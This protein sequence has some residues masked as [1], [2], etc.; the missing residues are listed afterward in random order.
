MGTAPAGYLAPCVAPDPIPMEPVLAAAGQDQLGA[1]L[2]STPRDDQRIFTRASAHQVHRFE[3]GLVV[4]TKK[5]GP[6][7]LPYRDLRIYRDATLNMKYGYTNTHWRFERSDGQVWE[8]PQ[9][10]DRGADDSVLAQ[11]YEQALTTTCARQRE[12]ALQRLAEGATLAFGP[13]ELDRSQL[14]FGY[15]HT[16]VA[17]ARVTQ[18]EV[19]DG[20]LMVQATRDGRFLKHALHTAGKLGEIA[21]FPLLW[22]LAHVAQR[23]AVGGG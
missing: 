7:T 11:I 19:K 17:W 20:K 22:E 23:Q 15:A 3:H 1:L 5:R 4:D 2:D 13:V 9:A 18:L 8:T 12:T 10:K 14:T 16:T 21:N 6:L